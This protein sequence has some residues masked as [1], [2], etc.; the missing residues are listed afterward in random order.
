MGEVGRALIRTLGSE[1]RVQAVRF[2][3]ENLQR[4]GFS[5][6]GFGCGFRV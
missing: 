1:S 2:R 3:M 6:Y 4:V 5:A